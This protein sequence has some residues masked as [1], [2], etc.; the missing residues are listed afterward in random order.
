MHALNGIRVLDLTAQVAGPFGTLALA[1]MGAE[2]I[3]VERPWIAD[4]RM[5]NRVVP[6]PKSGAPDRPYNR[7]LWFNEM[8][9]G[10]R[11]IAVDLTSAEGKGLILD[12]GAISDVIASNFSTRVMENLGLGY[13]AIKRVKPDIIY[14]SV[15][16]YGSYGPA[17]AWTAAGPAID[18]ASGVASLTGYHGGPPLRPGNFVADPIAGQYLTLGILMAIYER[19]Q[20][21]KGQRIDLSMLEGME[22]FIGEA[23]IG[24]STGAS[25]SAMAGNDSFPLTPHGCFPCRGEESWIAIAVENDG[26]WDSLCEEMGRPDWCQGAAFRN[27]LS[28]WQHRETLQRHVAEWTRTQDRSELMKRLQRCRIPAVAVLTDADQLQSAHLGDREYFQMIDHPELDPT[29][30]PRFGWKPTGDEIGMDQRAPLFGEHMEEVFGDL[31]GIPRERI[32]EL[33]AAQIIV[34]APK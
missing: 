30:Y 19:R 13:E 2:V 7:V 4:L 14:A 9:V 21:G 29:P 24:A 12:L 28:R 6:P 26:Q 3:K 15:S 18:A 23:L 16:G 33:L 27:S 32:D 31:L 25:V 20:S 1:R 5:S 34:T 22:H 10:K 11:S 8:N 17:A